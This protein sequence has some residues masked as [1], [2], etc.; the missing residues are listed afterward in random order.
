MRIATF[1]LA[2]ASAVAVFF[3]AGSVHGGAY[4][5]VQFLLLSPHTQTSGFDNFFY[6]GKPPGAD[7]E[8]S[9]DSDLEPAFRFVLGAD[10]CSGFGARVRYFRFDNDVNYTGEWENGGPVLELS[11]T[12]DIEVDAL[13]VELT[14]RGCVRCWDLGVAAG[15]R[16]GSVDIVETSDVFGGIPA[17]VFIGPTGVEFEGVGP[18]FAAEAFRPV[19]CTGL[20]IVGRARTALLFG[21][22]D[23]ASPF[24]PGGAFTVG[25]DFVQVWE[26]QFGLDY[27]RCAQRWDSDSDSLGDL[28][29]HGLGLHAGLGF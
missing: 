26:F 4:G 8:G 9:Y 24:I 5:D 1:T 23:G 12:V 17:A 14:Q 11:S 10:D 13:D 18:T 16:Y 29:L 28:A 20:S 22:I 6:R 25:D 3:A 19:G 2:A 21:D 15:L 27:T 7:T